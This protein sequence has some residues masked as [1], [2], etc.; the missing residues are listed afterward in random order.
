VI[1]AIKSCVD[2]DGDLPLNRQLTKRSLNTQH[3]LSRHSKI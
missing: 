3:S 2:R 1:E